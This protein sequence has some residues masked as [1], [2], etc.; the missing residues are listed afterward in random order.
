MKQL[1]QL[2]PHGEELL[3]EVDGLIVKFHPNIEALARLIADH[4]GIDWVDTDLMVGCYAL[5][6]QYVAAALTPGGDKS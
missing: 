6:R 3:T 4:H 1:Y 2:T 5:A